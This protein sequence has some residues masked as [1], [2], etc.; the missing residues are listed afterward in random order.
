[1]GK[2]LTASDMGKL[3]GRARAREL[4]A[5]ERKRI[6]R[7]GGLARSKKLKKAKVAKK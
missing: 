2:K 5:T 3:G 6:A 4:D 7:L 1:M